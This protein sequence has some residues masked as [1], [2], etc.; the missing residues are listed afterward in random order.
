MIKF[1]RRVYEVVVVYPAII[2]SVIEY[3]LCSFT[4]FLKFDFNLVILVILSKAKL[5]SPIQREELEKASFVYLHK[6]TD[7]ISA[8]NFF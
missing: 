3:Y 4:A 8:E 5:H 7:F 6:I 1:K 2:A